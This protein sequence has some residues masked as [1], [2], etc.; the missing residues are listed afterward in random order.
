MQYGREMG[1]KGESG[2][3]M[4][5]LGPLDT[6][7]RSLLLELGPLDTGTALSPVLEPFE[8]AGGTG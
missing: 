4:L 5:E 2:F 8:T 6:G 7:K 1:P 3:N